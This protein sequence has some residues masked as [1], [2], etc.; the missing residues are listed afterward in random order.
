MTPG[1]RR[2]EQKV[3]SLMRIGGHVVYLQ[4]GQ[5]REHCRFTENTVSDARRSLDLPAKNDKTEAVRTLMRRS[6]YLKP[7][8]LTGLFCLDDATLIRCMSTVTSRHRKKTRQLCTLRHY[9]KKT[10]NC[11]T[12][13]QSHTCIM[14]ITCSWGCI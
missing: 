8:K 14:P 5:Q 1:V 10:H 6:R 11:H 2:I 3:Y 13:A 4:H 12:R 9:F 7:Q